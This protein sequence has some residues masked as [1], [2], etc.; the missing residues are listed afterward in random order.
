M[1]TGPRRRTIVGA[2]IGL[3][4]SVLVAI[5]TVALS[6]TGFGTTRADST[7]AVRWLGRGLGLVGL[8]SLVVEPVPLFDRAVSAALDSLGARQPPTPAPA[9]VPA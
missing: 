1:G 4:G 3:V 9:A 2:G 6:Y 8:V 7:F 5:A